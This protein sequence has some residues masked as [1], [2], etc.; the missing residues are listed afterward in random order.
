MGRVRRNSGRL[1]G[2]R[3]TAL[4]N[5]FIEQQGGGRVS[6]PPSAR[7]PIAGYNHSAHDLIHADDL[8]G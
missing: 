5:S 7:D 6:T 1:I 3:A 4:L 2:T 8:D